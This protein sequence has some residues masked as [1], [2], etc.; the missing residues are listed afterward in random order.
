MH[1]IRKLKSAEKDLYRKNYD[2]KLRFYLFLQ[3]ML[4]DYQTT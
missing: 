4:Y 3:N 2:Q 1:V